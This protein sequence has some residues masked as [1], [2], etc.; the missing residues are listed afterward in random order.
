MCAVR[1]VLQP[2]STTY[3]TSPL[4]LEAS[5][6]QQAVERFR[7][8]GTGSLRPTALATVINRGL[9][10]RPFVDN[11]AKQ[12]RSSSKRQAGAQRSVRVR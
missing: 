9:G 2:D 4:C 7:L 12:G 11:Y 1:G 6:W 8:R 10:A 5:I 3:C